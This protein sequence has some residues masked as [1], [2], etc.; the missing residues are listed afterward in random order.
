MTGTLSTALSLLLARLTF[1]FV[2]R[3][4]LEKSLE[5]KLEE[6]RTR[7]SM[8]RDERVRSQVAKWA[9][10]ILMAARDL[11]SRLG[12]LINEAGYLPLATDWDRRKPS[13]WSVTHDY[14]LDSTLYLFGRYFACVHLL[15]TELGADAFPPNTEKDELFQGVRGVAGA[16][17]TYPAIFN[18]EGCAGADAQLLR[19]Q[20][21]ALAEVF[22]DRGELRVIS[23]AEF[24]DRK[25]S[26]RVHLEPLNAVLINLAPEPPGNCRWQR[27]LSVVHPLEKVRDRC[28]QLL[29]DALRE[30]AK[31][32]LHTTQ[33]IRP[34]RRT[35]DP[36]HR[37]D[38]A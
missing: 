37:E 4:E 31:V 11:H 9:D 3:P 32:N 15:R 25:S 13:D 10:P 34:H 20:Q 17:S 16:L 27:L 28:Q 21:Q 12:N 38:S 1:R 23:F 29:D 5:N 30:D 33:Q 26:L 19:W 7:R 6:E 36:K 2:K 8:D 22:V 35:A 18:D 24:L 14:M